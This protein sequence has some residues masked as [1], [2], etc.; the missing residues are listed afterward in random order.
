MSNQ[1]PRWNRSRAGPVRA[2]TH[3]GRVQTG[4]E[5]HKTLEGHISLKTCPNWAFEMF[6]ASKFPV[7]AKKHLKRPIRISF[8]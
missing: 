5:S 3:A 7:D 6:L 1:D 2:H 4:P 8:E